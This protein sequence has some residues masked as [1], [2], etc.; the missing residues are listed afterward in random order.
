VTYNADNTTMTYRQKFSYSGIPSADVVMES[1]NYPFVS[2][3][4]QMNN[5][6]S[7]MQQWQTLSQ[8]SSKMYN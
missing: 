5:M 4:Y 8:I 7:F 3:N 2:V 1:I 6:P